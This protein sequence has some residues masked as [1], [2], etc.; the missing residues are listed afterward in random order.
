MLIQN[1]LEKLNAWEQLSCDIRN[2]SLE[3]EIRNVEENATMSLCVKI[4]LNMQTIKMVLK[5][6]IV[7]LI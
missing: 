3:E 2:Y 1:N 7:S 6:T 5:T 4:V